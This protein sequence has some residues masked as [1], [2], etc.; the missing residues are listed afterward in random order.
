MVLQAGTLAPS[1]D[2]FAAGAQRKDQPHKVDQLAQTVSVGVRPEVT[3]A[4]VTHEAREDY[5]GERLVGDLQVRIAFVVAQPNVKRRLVTL[6]EVRFKDQRLDFVG[7]DDRAD[8][9]DLLDHCRRAGMVHGAFLKVRPNAVAQRD[10][11]SDVENLAV[12]ADHHVDAR[13][14][15]DLR[16][17]RS[18]RHP[19]VVGS[20]FALATRSSPATARTATPSTT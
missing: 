13:R 16:Q 18:Q 10:R 4:V 1:V 9:G 19:E 11:L 8:V 2:R 6:D 14:I 12:A 17:R 3:R 7:D 15:R 20:A 5:P